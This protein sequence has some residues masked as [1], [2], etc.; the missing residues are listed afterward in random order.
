MTLPRT[1]WTLLVLVA[2]AV[3]GACAVSPTR[4]AASPGSDR[5]R[6]G[7]VYA[8]E[9]GAPSIL[10]VGSTYYAYATNTDG[11]NL[12][13]ITSSDLVTWRAR[14]AWP[15]SAEFST[16]KGYADA[17]PFPAPWA[18]KLDNGKPG[19][20]SPAVAEL[21][22]R[23]VDAY[24]V[25]MT[26]DSDRHCLTLATSPSPTGPFRDTSSKPLYCSSDP[27]GSI[28][29]AWL[30]YRG[31]VFLIWKNAGI[32]GVKKTDIMVRRMSADGSGFYPGSRAHEL[33]TT[34]DAWEGS[35]IEAPS[36]VRYG[37]RFYLFYSGN[38]Y[39]D[40]SYGIGY[41]VCRGPLGPCARPRSRPLL[42]SGK[43]VAGPGA[44]SAFVDEHGKLRLA[45]SAWRPGQVG[46]PSGPECR[47]TKAGCNQR[48]MYIATLA[49]D[50]AGRLTVVDRG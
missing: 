46:Y 28:D 5:F 32:K 11:N 47:D 6:A 33:L 12:P 38:R 45:Y 44:Q 39:T 41:A 16:W 43:D 49:Q 36:M 34:R 18:A 30:Q 9:F 24:A 19:V 8:G 15:R 26:R 7:E 3:L 21:G 27:R 1:R 35:V 14:K 22:G 48:R 31:K 23:Y 4:A 40:S 17:M 50:G 2:A 10:R 37:G 13:V 25:Q 20:W 42:A 29:P